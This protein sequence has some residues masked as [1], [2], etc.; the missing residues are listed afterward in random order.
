MEIKEQGI[1]C[2]SSSQKD[3]SEG[4]EVVNTIKTNEIKLI[5][6]SAEEA[7]EMFIYWNR[8]WLIA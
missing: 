4:A 5:E 2:D 3:G 1:K 6:R 8:R 7:E